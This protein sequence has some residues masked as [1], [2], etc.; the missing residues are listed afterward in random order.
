MPY[1]RV[2]LL[3]LVAFAGNSLLC[4]VALAHTQI[5]AASF[6]SIRLVSGAVVLWALV[7]LRRGEYSGRGN[8][9]SALA[10]FVYAA[11]FSFAYIQLNTGIGALILFGAVQTSMIAYGLWRGERFSLLQWLGLLLGFIGLLMVVWRKLTLPSPLDHVTTANMLTVSFQLSLPDWVRALQFEGDLRLRAQS[12]L[13]DA[14]RYLL[15]GTGWG[16]W[17]RWR[18]R[19]QRLAAWLMPSRLLRMVRYATD[20]SLPQ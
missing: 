9:L 7:V 12:E 14:P 8:W 17:L 20:R 15:D 1:T 18:D 4:R 16:K 5:D 11:G 3:A 2:A 6:T 13:F 10:L 19:D